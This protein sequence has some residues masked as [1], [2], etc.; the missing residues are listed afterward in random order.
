MAISRGPKTVTNGLVL[1]LDAADKNSYIGSGT[2]WTDVS[3]NGNVGTL[4]NSPTFNSSNGGNIVFDGV[5]DYVDNGNGNS[6]NFGTGDF[7]I[8]IWATRFT[9][10]TTNLRLLAKGADNDLTT[11]AGF[12]FFG[13]DTGLNFAINPS[14]TRTIITAAS[15]SVGEWFQ[16]IGLVERSST[17]RT[18]KNAILTNS[19]SS[20]V[21]SVSN[22]SV[23]LNISRN[24]AGANLY[25]TGNVAIVRMYNRSLTATE[26]SQNYNATK[27]RFGL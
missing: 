7:T 9:N 23:N 5:D 25:W 11:S 26:I 22:A 27:S 3:G 18:Y 6:I 15:Y 13:S 12:A 8:E 1:C 17:M 16:I 19:A 20:P 14:G 24:T 10:V 2:T 21:G 4:T